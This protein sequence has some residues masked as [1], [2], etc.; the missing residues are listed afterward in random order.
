M[1]HPDPA[2]SG[3]ERSEAHEE[4]HC[5]CARSKGQD[6]EGE[7][8]GVV[9]QLINEGKREGGKPGDSERLRRHSKLKK[10][11]TIHQ[12]SR[13]AHMS[14]KKPESDKGE[15]TECKT[16]GLW[17]CCAEGGRRLVL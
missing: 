4:Q 3:Q 1:K 10:M 5:E 6:S 17:L 16:P 2:T 9:L 12:A 14:D 8:A 15:I 13:K 7:I 11:N